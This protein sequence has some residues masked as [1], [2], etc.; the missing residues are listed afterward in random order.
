VTDRN[1]SYGWP[2]VYGVYGA[3]FVCFARSAISA[4]IFGDVFLTW[5]FVS[6][7][8]EGLLHE[9]GFRGLR[10]GSSRRGRNCCAIQSSHRR[11]RHCIHGIGI[12]TGVRHK[13]SNTTRACDYE[14]EGEAEFA[15]QAGGGTKIPKFGMQ[16]AREGHGNLLSTPSPL[17]TITAL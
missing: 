7:G 13:N 6:A 12:G 1:R 11:E 16:I 3:R 17:A 14:G 10:L 2:L 9:G 8:L 5:R 15:A 4:E